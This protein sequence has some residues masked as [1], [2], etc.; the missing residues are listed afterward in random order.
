M[1]RSLEIFALIHLALIGL[2]HVVQH[3]AWAEFFIRLRSI[4]YGGVFVHGFLSLGFG[5]MILA[6]HRVWSGAPMALTILG[7]LY[8]LKTA[9]CF[10]LPGLSMRSLNRVTLEGSRVFIGAGVMML[11]FAAATTIALVR[12][13]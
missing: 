13:G 2:S 6:F 10:M 9:Q 4:G 3:R 7:V 11:A 12:G 8:L 1:M 5:S